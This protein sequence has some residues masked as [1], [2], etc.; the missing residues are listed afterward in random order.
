[1]KGQRELAAVRACLAEARGLVLRPGPESLERALELLAP[2]EASLKADG[3]AAGARSDAVRLR[4]EIKELLAL[5]RRA[6]LFYRN[7]AGLADL[8]TRAYTPRGAAA[9]PEQPGRLVTEG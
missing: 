1:M 6:A 9:P 5:A 2:L 3:A 7:C 4:S 8:G